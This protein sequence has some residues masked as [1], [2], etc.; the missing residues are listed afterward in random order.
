MFRINT[1]EYGWETNVTPQSGSTA[2]TTPTK[3]VYIPETGSR[4]FLSVV[5]EMYM[6]D[7]N[8][9][10]TISAMTNA[11]MSCSIDT[12]MYGEAPIPLQSFSFGSEHSCMRWYKDFTD[13]FQ[14]NFTGSSHDV[15]FSWINAQNNAGVWVGHSFLLTCTYQYDDTNVETN[16][17]TIKLPIDN[18][19][20]YLPTSSF[21][22]GSSTPN[23][24]NI[25]AL[26]SF[27]P[28]ASKSYKDIYITYNG[29]NASST[30]SSVQFITNI[31]SGS[32]NPRYVQQSRMITDIA[33]FDI[34]SLSGSIDTSVSHA[35]SGRSTVRNRLAYFSPMLNITYHY[36]GNAS[37]DIITNIQVPFHADFYGRYNS[38][39]PIITGNITFLIP[40]KSISPLLNSAIVLHSSPI[41][42]LIRMVTVNGKRLTPSHTVVR[43]S[44]GAATSNIHYCFGTNAVSS[45]DYNVVP[46]YNVLPI[47][48]DSS[49]AASTTTAGYV[50]MTYSASKLASHENHNKLVCFSSGAFFGDY[51]G[52]RYIF[53]QNPTESIHPNI[54][55]SYYMHE[56][57]SLLSA[58]GTGFSNL[59]I[60]MGVTGSEYFA[61]QSA[62]FFFFF[63]GGSSN[64][65]NRI[66]S[67]IFRDTFKRYPREIDKNTT[68][69]KNNQ[70]YL[71][72]Y[73]STNANRWNSNYFTYNQNIYRITGSLENCNSSSVDYRLSVFCSGS[74][75]P[76][77][78]LMTLL[79][80]GS[81]TTKNFMFDWYENITNL[82]V[83]STYPEY[84]VSNFATASSNVDLM[85]ID[86]SSVSSG[87]GHSYTFIG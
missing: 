70:F 85:T 41:T 33:Y 65:S 1:V 46:G 69:F 60:Y 2:Y 26:D 38:L 7:A 32:D 40:E 76:K 63:L 39:R 83:V 54:T 45:S 44:T 10:T 52:V 15:A 31:D 35:L 17:K 49:A 62:F 29:I 78:A 25:P 55:S 6:R 51:S 4:Q 73:A 84:G 47:S 75:A 50:L 82:Y 14:T 72:N 77:N 66:L 71:Y 57:C 59:F 22:F 53:N 80:T 48:I 23:F 36:N 9:G 16:I 27:L 19:I 67:Y 61:T 8:L 68:F 18:Y 74:N 34:Q 81:G 64:A 24:T 43:Q 5:A 37:N 58:N 42:S 79:S 56:P 21:V 86:F 12:V 87:A 30:T 3:R 20:G 28:E 13:I 11:G